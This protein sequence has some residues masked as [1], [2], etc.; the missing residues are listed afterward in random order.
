MSRPSIE[1]GY[2]SNQ[3]ANKQH[4][5]AAP[6]SGL[7]SHSF[8]PSQAEINRYAPT[9][10]G[11]AKFED[12]LAIECQGLTE[13]GQGRTIAPYVGTIKN[14]NGHPYPIFGRTPSSKKDELLSSN[15]L[16]SIAKTQAGKS[17]GHLMINLLSYKG[18]ILVNDPKTELYQCTSG[19]RS[20]TLGQKVYRFAP[21]SEESNVWNPLS[22]IR[23]DLNIPFENMSLSQQADE[24]EDALFLAEMLISPSGNPDDQFWENLARCILAGVLLYVATADIS[25]IN[26]N[27]SLDTHDLDDDDIEQIRLK[28][29]IH[30]RERSMF[31]VARLLFVEPKA[32]KILLEQMMKST[33]PMIQNSAAQFMRLEAGEG[34]IAQSVFA[35]LIAQLNIWTSPRISHVT[36]KIPTA[37]DPLQSIVNDFDFADLAANATTIYINFESDLSG[38]QSVLRVLVG[39]AM[40]QLKQHNRLPVANSTGHDTPP[41]LFLLDEFATLGYMRSIEEALTYIAGYNVRFWFFVQDICQLKQHYPKSWT[42]FFSNT[43]TQCFYGINEIETAKLISEMLG[44]ATVENQTHNNGTTTAQATC[45]GSNITR[46]HSTTTTH[47]SR[48]LMTPD[49]VQL[50]SK[51]HLLILIHGIRPILT[52]LI[53]YFQ[54]PEL[55]ARSQIP[56]SHSKSRTTS[57]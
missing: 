40:R 2:N 4:P 27:M 39:T 37:D 5:L 6:F 23:T 44:Y 17:S 42:T 43:G 24:Q 21:E 10:Y 30:V 51:D 19:Y 8:K 11:S 56:P 47:V 46:N 15:H 22:S 38:T 35:M 13:K 14:N 25:D 54:L 49:E 33:R 36:Y 31:E 45:N 20:N 7:N 9:T 55:R 29:L 52:D 12:F 41:V 32:F 34:K 28:D 3:I 57:D 26:Q 48:P 18:S 50:A 16:L 53:K 1:N